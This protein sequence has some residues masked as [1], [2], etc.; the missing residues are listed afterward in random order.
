MPHRHRTGGIDA[1]VA[2]AG[3]N[4]ANVCHDAYVAL[5]VLEGN[6][7]LPYE[8]TTQ[9]EGS[10]HADLV[11]LLRAIVDDTSHYLESEHT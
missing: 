11:S 10:R 9:N 1:L 7:R 2:L 8:L 4:D 5:R 3:A 6:S